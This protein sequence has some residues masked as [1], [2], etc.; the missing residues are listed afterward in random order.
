MDL[1]LLLRLLRLRRLL[2]I[3]NVRIIMGGRILSETIVLGT[4]VTMMKA[5]PIMAITGETL[6]P[7]SIHARLAA[8]AAVATMLTQTQI[9]QVQP[10]LLEATAAASLARGNATGQKDVDSMCL[11]DHALMLC[12]RRS[13]SS[14]IEEGGAGRTGASGTRIQSF[15]P[16]GGIEVASECVR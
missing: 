6:I 13:V 9:L 11:R 3:V 8:T 14:G 15:A 12:Q 10:R 5:A 2:L 16:E 1:R 7:V 4:R